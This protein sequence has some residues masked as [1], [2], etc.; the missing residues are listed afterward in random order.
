[1]NSTQKKVTK[2]AGVKLLVIAQSNTPGF[3]PLPQV[4]K[5]LQHIHEHAPDAKI[6]HGQE[7]T[8]IE[9]MNA[10]R[11]HSWVHFACHGIQNTADLMDSGLRLNDGL[12]QLS[13]IIKEPLPN[14]EF[15]F[16]SACQTAAGDE[17]HP[18]EAIHLAA[19]ML[20]A[21]YHGV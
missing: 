13:D 2:K 16:L 19:G 10:M 4:E 20:L 6:L 9:V 12:L 11:N 18:E 15:A 8:I 17:S 21:G 7:A 3:P 14:A 5:E 1:M